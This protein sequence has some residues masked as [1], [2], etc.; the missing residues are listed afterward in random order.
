MVPRPRVGHEE[1]TAAVPDQT[2]IELAVLIA[3]SLVEQADALERLSAATEKRD[4]ID[5]ARLPNAD[6]E[7]G[8]ADPE[9]LR[10]RDRDGAPDGRLAGG[11]RGPHAHH[12]VRARWLEGRPALADVSASG[13]RV[14]V[15]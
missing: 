12:G 6:T 13:Q 11:R 10:Q 14:G 7:V 1:H 2:G 15:P 5:P 9:G 4:R 8:V 3:L